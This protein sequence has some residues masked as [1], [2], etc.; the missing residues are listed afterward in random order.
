MRLLDQISP[1][2]RAELSTLYKFRISSLRV[3]NMTT[4]HIF[5]VPALLV[6]PFL[7]FLPLLTTAQQNPVQVEMIADVSEIAPGDSFRAGVKITIENGWHIYG[8][9]PGLSGLPTKVEWSLPDGATAGSVQYP[10][11]KPFTFLGEP[12]EGY[13]E[14]VILWSTIETSADLSEPLILE[15]ESSWLVCKE[16]CMPGRETAT[17]MIPIGKTEP[18]PETAEL[19]FGNEIGSPFNPEQTGTPTDAKIAASIPSAPETTGTSLLSIL[20][21]GLVGGLILNLMPCVFPIIGIKIMGFVNQA[22]ASR[23]KVIAH[24]LVFTT[25][26]LLSFWVLAGILIALRTG[27]HELG[28][29]F[30]LQ[31]PGFVFALTVILL[32]FGLNMSGLF[33]FGLTAVGAGNQ[34]TGKSGITGTFFSGILATVVATPCAAPFLAPALGAA[35]TLPPAASIAAFTAIAIGL[36]LPYLLLSLFPGLIKMLPKPGPWMETLKQFLSFLLYGTVAFLLWVLAGQLEPELL[37]GILFALVAIALAC[38]VYGR[39]SA[40]H[41]KPRIQWI[42]RMATL[43]L[44]AGPLIYAGNGIAEQSR[45]QAL[46]DDADRDFLVWQNW[47]PE[48]EMAFREEGRFVYIDFTA[49]WCATCQWNKRAYDD[50]KVIRK[51]LENDVVL[52]KADWTNQDPAITR[53]LAEFGRSAVPFNLLYS[54]QNDTPLIMPELFGADTVLKKLEEAGIEG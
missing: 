42:A 25:G 32:V 44:L 36:S 5:R 31:E 3:L 11:T 40:P 15:T 30:Q 1:E 41:R 13:T 53:A 24:G 12:G 17:L 37:L 28:W 45:R 27:G 51:F 20:A 33:E 52:L 23:R 9:D 26:V 29:G 46:A 4:R 48:K 38:W 47:S 35:L 34:L 6:L 50:P 2:I 19:F 21:I 43:I 16:V 14:T 10:P 39:W 54:P 22:G 49:R 7:L 8:E 18:N